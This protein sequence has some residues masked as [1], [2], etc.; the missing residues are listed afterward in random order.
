MLMVHPNLTLKNSFKVLLLK[1]IFKICYLYFENSRNSHMNVILGFCLDTKCYLDIYLLI[2]EN[3]LQH[4]CFWHIC[5][6]LE[7][8]GNL[9]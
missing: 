8:N 2:V 5:L 3:P 4:N 9:F 7:G 6:K 1:Y